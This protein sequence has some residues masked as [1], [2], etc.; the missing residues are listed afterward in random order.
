MVQI[1]MPCY[2]CASIHAFQHEKPKQP[3][4]S[5][6]PWTQTVNGNNNQ[7]LPEKAPAEELDEHN[8]KILQK[9]VGKLLY[10]AR[11][12][13]TTMLMA[14]NSLV[15]VQTKQTIKTAK[16]ITQ[17]LNYSATHLD[18]ITESRKME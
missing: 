1:S 14:L 4:D 15:E 9:I 10:H 5:S 13:D 16:Q 7:I 2:V 12:I 8:K 17:F 11:S 3:Q 18:A 6:Y